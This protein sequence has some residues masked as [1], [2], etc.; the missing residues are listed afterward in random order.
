M[1][2]KVKKKNPEIILRDG[3]P[4]AIILDIEEYQELLE[5]LEDVEDLKMLE[6]MRKKPLRFRKLEDFLNVS[7]TFSEGS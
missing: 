5:R 1:R 6:R 3:K 2:T 4:A 7:N